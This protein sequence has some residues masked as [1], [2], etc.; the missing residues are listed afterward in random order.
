[1]TKFFYGPDD[2][3]DEY[4]ISPAP[5]ISIDTE[6]SYANDVLLGYVYKI[7]IT[8]FALSKKDDD[9]YKGLPRVLSAVNNIQKILSRNGSDLT[10][11][12]E[13][14]K[15]IIKAKGGT[16]RSLSFDNGENNWVAFAPFS[17]EIDFNELN[18]LNDN[19]SCNNIY[20]NSN[21]HSTNL[22]DISKY[23]IKEF[24]D[25]WNLS[26]EDEGYNFSDKSDSNGTLNINNSVFRLT[27]NVSAV[28]KNYYQDDLLLPAWVHAKNFSQ[29]RLTNRVKDVVNSLKYSGTSCAPT[30]SLSSI[31]STGAGIHQSVKQNYDIFNETVTC[32]A[33][34]SD[35]S[36]N[37]EY[38]CILKNKSTSGFTSVNTIHTINKSIN[39]TLQ[40][41][42]NNINISIEGN[43]QGLCP[44]G[45]FQ[46]SGNFSIPDSGSLISANSTGVRITFA[47]DLLNNKILDSNKKDLISSLKTALNITKE[48]LEIEDDKCSPIKPSSFTLTT[49]FM[50]GTIT[51]SF[52]YDSNR[53]TTENGLTN[54]RINIE[55]PTDILSELIIPNGDYVVQ[56]IGTKTA[57]RVTLTADVINRREC[58]G[59]D[60]NGAKIIQE[61]LYFKENSMEDIFK[62]IIKFPDEEI[63]TITSKEYSYNFNEGSYNLTLAYIC[64]PWCDIRES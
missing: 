5:K 49:N 33:S 16:L 46:G 58:C 47:Q 45:L 28:G 4:R 35:G 20:I 62:D 56:D 29:H 18:I 44:G 8:G 52:V 19:F 50:D 9:N 43:I 55:E 6:Y 63:Y 26:L 40:G 23:K 34:E 38:S 3:S 25:S 21:S 59:T 15:Q 51:Y 42:K 36:F 10:I 1:M 39:K 11:F 64:N 14:N 41:R 12:D 53:C 57:K 17:A 37:L 2:E 7:T 24:T 30:D 61:L 22:V 54:V 48:E 32:T 13:D 27:Y 31:H 60:D